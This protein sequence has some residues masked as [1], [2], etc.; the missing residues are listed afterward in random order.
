MSAETPHLSDERLLLLADGELKPRHAD[1]AK[2]HL[3]TCNSCRARFERIEASAAEFRHAYQHDRDAHGASAAPLRRALKAQLADIREQGRP[4]PSWVVASALLVAAL[5]GVE[6]VSNR[7]GP[8]ARPDEPRPGVRPIAYLTPGATRPVAAADLC[9]MRRP[10][11]RVIPVRVRQAVVRDYRMELVSPHEYELDYLITPELG[12]SDDRRN[13]WPER[14]SSEL[15][16]AR[17][18][19]ELEQLLPRL[20]CSGTVPL[21]AA[22]RDMATDWI[23]A[24]KKYF[25]TDRPLHAYSPFASRETE[26]DRAPDVLLPDLSFEF[27]TPRSNSER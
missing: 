15:W 9:A 22:Q 19:D 4:Q 27:P 6:F 18:K 26:D 7:S 5:L 8:S 16:N 21:A 1:G 13:L 10:A 25:H 11:P 2:R 14:Y 17:V 20:V 3:I 24:Y 23:A 12:G